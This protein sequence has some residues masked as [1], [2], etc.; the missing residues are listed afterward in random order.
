MLDIPKRHALF[1]EAQLDAS[2]QPERRN[3]LLTFQHWSRACP[4]V[5]SISGRY[6]EYSRD[7][8]AGE[9]ANRSGDYRPPSGNF[10]VRFSGPCRS[11]TLRPRMCVHPRGPSCSCHMPRAGSARSTFLLSESPSYAPHCG[12]LS[13]P[14]ENGVSLK[15]R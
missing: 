13:K 10:A 15:L 11:P 8:L 7:S 1:N 2:K 6:P 5:T 4:C 12:R 9:D 3:L 14:A